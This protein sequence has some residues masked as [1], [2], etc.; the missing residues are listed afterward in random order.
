LISASLIL[1][2]LPI[3]HGHG[4]ITFKYT[5]GDSMKNPQSIQSIRRRFLFTPA[6][7]VA[8]V[9]CL[10]PALP[11]SV[12]AQE[13]Q[14]E[15]EKVL[16]LLQEPRHRTVH[17]DG[18][19]YLLDVQ[20]NPGDESFAHT[21]DQ[22]I[23]LT[24]IS[25]ASGPQDG[26]VS[27]NTDYASEPFTHK[28]SN[29]GPGLLRILAFVNGSNGTTSTGDLPSGF[30]QAPQL[31]NQ[32]FRSWRIELEPGESTPMQTHQQAGFVAQVSDGVVHVTRE[33]GI[34]SELDA[35]GDWQWRK[36]GIGYS[37]KNAGSTPVAVVINEGRR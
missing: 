22:A 29:D 34:T 18:D 31:E 37:V 3:L 6:A 7:V 10:T 4:G 14:F 1:S 15:G 13:N 27:A 5:R 9:A 33:D 23:L 25:S 30:S 12:I 35:R 16:H 26:Q 36:A 17:R 28:I 11:G 24:R 20:A 21:H 19:L 8:A 32:W 2:Q